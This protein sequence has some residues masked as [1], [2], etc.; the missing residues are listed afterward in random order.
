MS[1]FPK[2]KKKKEKVLDTSNKTW[3]SSTNY[4]EIYLYEIMPRITAD[5]FSGKKVLSKQ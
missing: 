4:K 5:E 1:I 3:E 2:S